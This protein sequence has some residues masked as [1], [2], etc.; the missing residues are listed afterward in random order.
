MHPDSSFVAL[1]TVP[2]LP[3][4]HDSHQ[5]LPFIGSK[6]PAGQAEQSDFPRM[7]LYFP[8]MHL[9]QFAGPILF[10]ALPFLHIKINANHISNLTRQ[11][12]KERDSLALDTRAPVGACIPDIAR[13]IFDVV[14]F[15]GAY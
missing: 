5:V 4:G 1:S 3:D 7:S 10:L 13:A 2:A 11:K 12:G 15:R 8:G 9:E 14:V 6:E